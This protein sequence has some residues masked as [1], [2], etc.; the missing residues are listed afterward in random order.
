LERRRVDVVDLVVFTVA[1]YAATIAVQIYQPATGG[2]FNL[3]ESVIY[4]AALISTPIVAGVAGGVGAALADLS[5]GYAIFAPATLV[6]KFAEG[7]LAG[8]LT[9]RVKKTS[10][11][12]AV[13][14][15]AGYTALVIAF[16]S[17]YWAGVVQYGPG[18]YLGIALTPLE[19]TIPLYAWVLVALVVGGL[20][21]YALYKRFVYGSEAV[22]LL[23][24]GMVM[25][26]GYFLYE[27]FISNPLTMRPPEAALFEVPVNIGQAVIG[28]FVAVPVAAWLRR[29][30]YVRE[31]SQSQHS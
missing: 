31:R 25:V 23:L 22:L 5:T 9:R 1:V 21:T 3:G 13:L 4:L 28:A 7:Y 11:V 26:T 17:I 20:A 12:L 10:P 18:E 19:L 30:G 2:Y 15:G 27:Y 8:L 14:V 24:A 29:A 16:A 6:I